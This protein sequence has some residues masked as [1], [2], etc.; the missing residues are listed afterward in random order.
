MI[1]LRKNK[2][3][4]ILDLTLEDFEN[5]A[6]RGDIGPN[7]E[8]K[9][10]A[11]TGDRFV[12]ASDIEFF[13]A[14]SH[15]PSIR[16]Q[17]YFTLARMPWCTLLVI[18][19]T[20]A[21]FFGHQGGSIENEQELLQQGAKSL[22]L[23]REQGQ[24]WRLLT[25]NLLHISLWHLGVNIFFLL[26]IGGPAEAIFR[27]TDFI[28]LILISAL[29]T[30]ALS[31]LVNPETSCGASG[32]V[33]GLWG[34]TAVFGLRYRKI[35]PRRYQRY[36]IGLVL[37]YSIIALYLGFTLE[38]IDN[39][40]HVGGL[41]G[42]IFFGFFLPPRLLR[43]TDRYR[44]QKRLGVTLCL[45][46]LSV[47]HW[48]AGRMPP[49]SEHRHSSKLGL[50][51][52]V[53]EEWK[54]YDIRSLDETSTK[55]EGTEY[56]NAVGV[57]LLV[58]S[59]RHPN[60]VHLVEGVRHFIETTLEQQLQKKGAKGIRI[61]AA[62]ERR[63]GSHRFDHF[64]VEALTPEGLFYSKIYVLSQGPMQ[65]ALS[66]SVPQWLGSSYDSYFMEILASLRLGDSDELTSVKQKADEQPP[67]SSSPPS[68]M[69]NP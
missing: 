24:W 12:T 63:I 32:I 1:Q 50:V 66:L 39:G 35:L 19:S 61:G 52:N 47:S 33:F 30:T 58:H 40:G 28:I 37:P 69:R 46:L 20:A 13:R 62:H 59:K 21:I 65:H 53:P 27:R 18:L 31:T 17:D 49:L 8:L 55:V 11:V 51:L 7:D 23:M 48:Y 25:A 6:Q 26:N 9:F 42:G 38:G 44:H 2:E 67:P 4:P 68:G 29:G 56:M 10:P 3:G 14:L 36:F 34:A 43:P 54:R 57:S 16:L 15:R 5:R 41:L 64:D 22:T 45:A 60:K